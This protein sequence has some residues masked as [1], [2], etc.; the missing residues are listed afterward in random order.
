VSSRGARAARGAAIA[1]FATFA[2][3]LAH[4]VGGGTPPGLLAILLALAFSAPLA[5]LL[6]GGRG[7]LLRAGISTL[8]A[9]ASLHL[10]YAVLGGAG[11]AVP[12]IAAP[13][14]GTAGAGAAA[15]A[16]HPGHG[17]PAVPGDVLTTPALVDHGHEFMPLTHAVAAALTLLALVA[18][19]RV[20]RAVGRAVRL[21]VRRITSI[22][23]AV[24]VAPARLVPTGERPTLIAHLPHAALSSRG[25]P[26][27]AVA[28]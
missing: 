23:A 19:D 12:G 15:H 28:S 6:A 1:G 8:G 24:V 18:G 21:F 5:M 4:T 22:P 26:V 25:P 17:S 13:S 3:A 16:G 11:L 14:G 10:C 27:V 2:A 20:L 7:H 9:Q